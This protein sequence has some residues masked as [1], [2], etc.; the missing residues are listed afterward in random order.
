M[1]YSSQRPHERVFKIYLRTVRACEQ[2]KL[3]RYLDKLQSRL[4]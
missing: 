3:H 1:N 4:K 2:L